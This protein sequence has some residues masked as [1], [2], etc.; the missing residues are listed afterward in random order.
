[1]TA[2]ESVEQTTTPKA[3]ASAALN[4]DSRW[5]LLPVLLL[6]LVGILA[7]LAGSWSWWSDSTTD[8]LVL[9]GL[10]VMALAVAGLLQN[11]RIRTLTV[12]SSLDGWTEA[13]HRA[14]DLEAVR[15][16][17]AKL[18]MALEGLSARLVAEARGLETREQ[19]LHKSLAELDEVLVE[20]RQ[21]RGEAREFATRWDDFAVSL[22]SVLHRSK[23]LEGVRAV[24]GDVVDRLQG[25][26]MDVI[27][28]AVS[29]MV[30]ERHHRVVATEQ[31][32]DV[33]TGGVIRVVSP[34]VRRG[35]EIL[36]PAEGGQAIRPPEVSEEAQATQI[37][38]P[39]GQLADE[40]SVGEPP[41][42][43]EPVDVSPEP[44]AE[45]V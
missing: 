43:A 33:E 32:P 39:E 2:R 13:E 18:R 17:Q 42:I 40:A 27:D 10:G 36:Q 29:A 37:D 45:G 14:A 23:D 5:G 4:F 24:Y 31:S 25:H 16:E 1:M 11:Q 9:A 30:D 44:L 12:A 26:G 41:T 6:T 35:G 8:S 7:L 28:P 3:P 19:G 15:R 34:G 38:Q 21:A 22:L 20:A